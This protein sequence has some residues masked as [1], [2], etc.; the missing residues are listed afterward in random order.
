MKPTSNG[1]FYQVLR[2]G[3]S[4]LEEQFDQY[5]DWGLDR[6]FMDDPDNWENSVT[7]DDEYF[8]ERLH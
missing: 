4:T 3:K 2:N 1:R 5:Q 6:D 7:E 8:E